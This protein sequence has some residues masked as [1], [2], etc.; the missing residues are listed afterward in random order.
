MGLSPSLGSALV[1]IERME[2]Q[3]C[4]P[5]ESRVLFQLRLSGNS[6]VCNF[7]ASRFGLDV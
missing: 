1:I 3:H 7:M 2:F 5:V 4:P 6:E